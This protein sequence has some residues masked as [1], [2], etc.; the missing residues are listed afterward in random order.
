MPGPRHPSGY[1]VLIPLFLA[2]LMVRQHFAREELPK[3]LLAAAAAYLSV[4]CRGT[5]EV[6]LQDDS[7]LLTTSADTDCRTSAARAS[8]D[9]VQLSRSWTRCGSA[10]KLL[11]DEEVSKDLDKLQ[12]R[13]IAEM[14]TERLMLEEATTGSGS[15]RLL[16]GAKPLLCRY[17][18]CQDRTGHLDGPGHF[19]LRHFTGY[20]CL[21]RCL[22][23]VTGAVFGNDALGLGHQTF[24]A[25]AG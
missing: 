14:L 11:A 23:I 12:C 18:L 20:L 13:R 5:M 8:A 1:G 9:G 19:A 3:R 16:V 6:T 25:A 4:H 24:H 2:T 22:E 7:V 17:T 10:M 21:L 15:S